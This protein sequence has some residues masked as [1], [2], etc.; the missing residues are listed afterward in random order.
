MFCEKC[1]F[2]NPDGRLSCVN[3]KAPLNYVP[4][5]G[6]YLEN[7]E[8]VVKNLFDTHIIFQ[9]VEN[10]IKIISK[11]LYKFSLVLGALAIGLG[12]ILFLIGLGECD[13]TEA[14]NL[15][16]AH[17][18]LDEDYAL[19]FYGKTLVISGLYCAASSLSLLPIYAFAEL[20]EN[21]KQLKH[22]N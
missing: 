12:V 9:N 13:F 14:L 17:V 22:Y 8:D 19:S 18:I 10:T 16:S 6:Y 20:L 2:E 1:G 11:F 7:T 15:T 4:R 21:I 5:P 3:C